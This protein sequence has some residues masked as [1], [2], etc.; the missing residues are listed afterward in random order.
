MLYEKTIV[1][2]TLSVADQKISYTLTETPLDNTY[3][4]V[5]QSDYRN[6]TDS[7][8]ASREYFR[9]TQKLKSG[10][11]TAFV[12]HQTTPDFYLKVFKTE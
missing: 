2:K 6:L 8:Q 12:F 10:Q 5:K 7:G 11:E 1:F 4:E 3:T 9:V